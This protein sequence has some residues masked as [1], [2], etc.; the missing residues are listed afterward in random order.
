MS[1]FREN[2]DKLSFVFNAL[3]W[4]NVVTFWIPCILSNDLN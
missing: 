2:K 1:L 4:L 3:L